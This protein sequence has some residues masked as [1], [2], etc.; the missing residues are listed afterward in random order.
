M[1]RMTETFSNR[2]DRAG[3]AR[4]SDFRIASENSDARPM[5]KSPRFFAD[6]REGAGLLLWKRRGHGRAWPRGRGF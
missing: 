5:H 1:R 2:G 3:A 6:G 4:D